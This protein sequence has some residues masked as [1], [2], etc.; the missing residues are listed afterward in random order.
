L[1]KREK[2]EK[3]IEQARMAAE[4][5]LQKQREDFLSRERKAEL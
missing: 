5:A 1:R 4:M 2:A 3:K